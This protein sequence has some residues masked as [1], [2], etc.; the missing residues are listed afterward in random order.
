[1]ALERARQQAEERAAQAGHQTKTHGLAEVIESLGDEL[2]QVKKDSEGSDAEKVLRVTGAKASLAVAIKDD[3][4]GKLTFTVL[5]IGG[6]V[7]GGLSRETTTTLEVDL[8]AIE[9]PHGGV[10]TFSGD[11][12]AGLADV[13]QAIRRAREA[14]AEGPSPSSR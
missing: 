5:G 4:S 13:A 7:S 1:V 6:E 8:L 12:W 11:R 10:V 2:R 14:A 3:G 9:G